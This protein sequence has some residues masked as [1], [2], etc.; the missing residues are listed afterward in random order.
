MKAHLRHNEGTTMRIRIVIALLLAMLVGRANAQYGIA[1]GGVT[2]GAISS[3]VS[4]KFGL[5]VS[6]GQPMLGDAGPAPRLAGGLQSI[7]DYYQQSYENTAIT[8][9]DLI[10]QVGDTFNFDFGYGAP[11][12]FFQDGIERDWELKV[13]FNS[14]VLEA[15]SYESIEDDGEFSTITVKG[16]ASLQSGMLISIKFLALLGND[17]MTVVRVA[18]FKWNDVPRQVTRPTLGSVTIK[19]LCTTYG[20]T[21]LVRATG[22]TSIL[23][24]P[25]PVTGSSVGLRVYAEEQTTGTVIIT[26]MHGNVVVNKQGVDANNFWPLVNV[27]LPVMPAGTYT[28]TYIASDNIARTTLLKLP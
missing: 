22:R 11:C 2:S 12:A 10:K 25:N 23:V 8:A 17:S 14:T 18:S 15:L 5:R 3:P 1:G 21:R 27:D 16:R 24:A 13:T 28:V 19:G 6:I 20:K 9:P 26:D 4:G 7:G